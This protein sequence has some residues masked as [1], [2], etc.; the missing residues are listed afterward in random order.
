MGIRNI[1][2]DPWLLIAE[3]FHQRGGMEKANAAL[4]EY[5]LSQGI[6]VY[7]V[8]YSIDPAIEKKPGAMPMMARTAARFGFLGRHG[9]ARLG[10]ASAQR[11]TR[12]HPNAHVL[13][14]GINCNCGDIIGSITPGDSES[15]MHRRG[16]G[17]NISSKL[18]SLFER[19]GMPSKTLNCYSPIPK[20]RG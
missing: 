11:V 9:L 7:L 8:A 18:L 20:K 13:A 5:L 15:K 1:K 12:H 4:A 16:S 6:P 17:S 2:Q 19:S 3:G 10:R 14:N